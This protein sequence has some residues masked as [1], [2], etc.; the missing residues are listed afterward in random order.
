[1]PSPKPK[2]L[3]ESKT[4]EA[5]LNPQSVEYVYG[6]QTFRIRPM[7]DAQLMLAAD[8]LADVAGV[9]SQA[10]AGDAD[11]S[12]LV[13]AAPA[14]FRAVLPR[15]TELLAA[16]LSLSQSQVAAIPLAHRLEILR[17]VLEAEDIPLL[18]KNLAALTGLFRKPEAPEAEAEPEAAEAPSS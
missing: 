2:P 12:A 16:S 18:L 7:T 3:L 15:S 1:M 10:L 17:V 14:V 8:A 13:A 5:V 11:T 6:G 4:P 9:L